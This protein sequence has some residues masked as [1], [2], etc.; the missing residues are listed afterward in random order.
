MLIIEGK[1][2]EVNTKF[3]LSFVAKATGGEKTEAC[4]PVGRCLA[5][6][7]LSANI[8]IHF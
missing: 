5:A 6:N 8:K 3:F 2:F 7:A 4:L 1:G